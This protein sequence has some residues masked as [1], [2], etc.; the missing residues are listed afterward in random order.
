MD[1][2]AST[3]RILV[4]D[5][6]E[7]T[8][9]LVAWVLR[10]LGFDVGIAGGGASALAQCAAARP[11]LIVLD[12]VMP[13]LD[14]WGVLARVAALSPPP[15]PVL[16][17]SA[18]GDSASFARAVREGAS[19]Y[20]FKP[21]PLEDLVATCGRLLRAAAVPAPG[22]ER[23]REPR[24]LL[25][26][27]LF[28]RTREEALPCALVD[29][30]RGGARVDSGRPL[31]EGASLDLDFRV[32]DRHA[33]YLSLRGRVQWR[34]PGAPGCVYGVAFHDLSPESERRLEDLLRP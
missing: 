2:S 24:R 17:I 13:G 12:L 9:A 5:D 21:F 16:V 32:P 11:D 19:G 1:G 18:L 10:D 8:R 22:A 7:D 30:S 20:L 27:A 4:V 15:P 34:D 28:G 23:R 26:L 6:E 33:P 14:G 25:S 3:R 29:L 31:D